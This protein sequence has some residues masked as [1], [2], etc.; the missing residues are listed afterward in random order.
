MAVTAPDLL[1]A[2]QTL[3]RVRIAQ[4]DGGTWAQIAPLVGCS[5]GKTAKAAVHALERQLRPL[6]SQ[7]AAA[8][9]MAERLMPDPCRQEVV[10]DEPYEC[11]PWIDAMHEGDSAT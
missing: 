1:A 9:A 4:Q 10:R 11:G 2:A 3:R 8:K 5:D 6:A 7:M